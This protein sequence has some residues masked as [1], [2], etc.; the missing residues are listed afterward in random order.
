MM[1]DNSQNNTDR[2]TRNGN[3]AL[4]DARQQR[5]QQAEDRLKRKEA[6]L[7]ENLFR[8]KRQAR[9]RKAAVTQASAPASS[10]ET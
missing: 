6:A 8:R 4:P 9:A 10:D 7:R 2:Q 3:A 1:S 5:A